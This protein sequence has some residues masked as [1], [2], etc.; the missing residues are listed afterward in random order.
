MLRFHELQQNPVS[1]TSGEES[2]ARY[3]VVA[4][5]LREGIVKMTCQCEHFSQEGW[6]NHCLAAFCNREVFQDDKHREAFEQLVGATYLQEAAVK[7]INALDAFAASYRQ[8]KSVRPS[9]VNR[10]QLRKF[11]EQA[12]RAGSSADDLAVVL[13]GFVNEAAAGRSPDTRPEP[14]NTS[15]SKDKLGALEMV[16]RALVRGLE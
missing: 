10:S 3:K 11:A 2:G 14:A 4:I 15:L 9:Q 16:R 12:Y 5:R 7:L 13:E 1:I 6:C 8:M